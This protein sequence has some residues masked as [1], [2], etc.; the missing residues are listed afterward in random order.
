MITTWTGN[1]PGI[2]IMLLVPSLLVL[3]ARKRVGKEATSANP[4]HRLA[5]LDNAAMPWAAIV[6]GIACALFFVVDKVLTVTGVW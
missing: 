1:L 5:A 2:A 3:V 4:L 6:F